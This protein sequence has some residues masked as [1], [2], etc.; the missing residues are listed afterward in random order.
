MIGQVKTSYLLFLLRFSCFLGVFFFA[1]VFLVFGINPSWIFKA[2]FDFQNFERADFDK[3]FFFFVFCL[4][5]TKEQFFRDPYSAI[6]EM[7]SS[8]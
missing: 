8:S 3:I 4:V 1:I 5:S 2:S 7:L 6:S